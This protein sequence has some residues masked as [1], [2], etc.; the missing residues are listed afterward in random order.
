MPGFKTET[1]PVE[2]AVKNIVDDEFCY[3]ATRTEC[4]EVSTVNDREICT[5]TYSS[6]K[7]TRG[8]TTTQVTYEDKSET[9]KVTACRASG[10]GQG[11]GYGHHDKGEHQYCREEYQTQEYRV[12]LVNTP[13]EVTV[14]VAVPEPQKVC[15]TKAIEVNEVV[16][17]DVS[18]E[19]CIGLA[20]L[21]DATVT[22]DQTAVVLGDPNCK[23]VT[24][25][26]PTEVC[27]KHGYPHH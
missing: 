3:T 14:E 17:K 24:L 27:S 12:P 20:A 25:T 1:T 7:E 9:M 10:Y 16:C 6:K 2:L 22:V 21:E 23:Q 4:E 26:L 18:E 8:A 19:R 5:Y 15:V 13:L 11:Y